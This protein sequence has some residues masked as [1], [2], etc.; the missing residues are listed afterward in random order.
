MPKIKLPTTSPKI[1]MTPMVD[2]FSVI[3]IFLMLT[4]TFRAS[5]PAPVDTPFS[6]SEKPTPD[7]DIMTIVLS[8]DNRVFFNVDNGPDTLLS[9]RPKILAAMGERY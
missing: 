5:E 6:I 4:T 9:F 7:F 3:L 2:L 1:D 8:A